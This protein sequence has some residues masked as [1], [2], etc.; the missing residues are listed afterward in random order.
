[1]REQRARDPQMRT[2]AFGAVV[3]AGLVMGFGLVTGLSEPASPHR[4]GPDTHTHDEDGRLVPGQS[5]ETMPSLPEFRDDVAPSLELVVD[6]NGEPIETDAGVLTID[7]AQLAAVEAQW[8]ADGGDADTDPPPDVLDD[9]WFDQP[10]DHPLD[11]R[12]Y[13]GFEVEISI[14]DS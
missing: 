8:I 7:V 3:V 9:E 10:T 1:M 5:S 2:I 13:A 6:S 12:W 4:H 11:P 14:G